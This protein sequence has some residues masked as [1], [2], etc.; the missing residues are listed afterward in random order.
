MLFG[1]WN[2]SFSWGW[3]S[4]LAGA[5]KA[6]QEQQWVL[7]VPCPEM[8][9]EMFH[10][11]LYGILYGILHGMLCGMLH[12][13]LH[14]MLHETFHEL[15]HEMLHG[16]IYRMLHG[17][18]HGT[19][20]RMLHGMIYGMLH[21]MLHEMPQPRHIPCSLCSSPWHCWLQ[22]RGREGRTGESCPECQRKALSGSAAKHG[23]RLEP[24]E[25]PAGRAG[26]MELEHSGI[27]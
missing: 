4:G 10:G 14:R 23:A 15:L 26:R 7:G 27:C 3:A 6:L 24:G 9:H 11:A 18:P 13:M 17:M 12:E 20:S 5:K 19:V 8:L 22:G 16:M 25:A 21:G 1:C 2:P